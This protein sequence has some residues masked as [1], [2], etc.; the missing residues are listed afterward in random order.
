MIRITIF[1]GLILL[2]VSCNQKIQKEDVSQELEKEIDYQIEFGKVASK[3]VFVSDTASIWGGSLVKGEDGKYHMFYSV[4]PK[5]IGW[6]WVN[7]SVIAHALSDSP[8]G[9]FEHKDITLPDR[10]PEYWDGSCTHNPTVH[11]INGKYY[12]YHMGNFGDEKIVSVPGKQRI[13]WMHRNNQRIGVAVADNPNGPWTRFDKPVLDITEGDSTA[14]DALMT[15]NPSVCQMPDGRILMVYK[16]VGKQY[17]LPAGGPVVHMVAI[18]DSPTGPFKKYPDPV[19]TFEGERF[20]AEDPYIWYA[21]GRYRAI[22]KRIKHIDHKRVF[23][24]VHYDSEDGINWN[25]AKYFEISDRTVTN[26][27]GSSYQFDHLERPQVFIEDGEP[28]ALLCAADT[29]DA[30][31]VRHSFNIQ[32]PLKIT[33]HAR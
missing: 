28:V 19:F 27:D 32:I 23:S 8:F 26:E 9:P 2:F 6:E 10:G 18:A 31:N 17:E 13:N 22:V 16:A 24:L 4:W 21:D 30:N 5:D 3:S 14:H 25:Q 29:I 33:K 1:F 12:L 15:S 20:P 11:K 7:Y